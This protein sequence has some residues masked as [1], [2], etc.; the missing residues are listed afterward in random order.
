MSDIDNLIQKFEA[1][2]IDLRKEKEDFDILAWDYGLGIKI[3]NEG[4]KVV[5]V[6]KADPF[7]KL[8]P[9]LVI[10]NGMNQRAVLQKRKNC[11]SRLIDS[12]QSSILLLREQKTI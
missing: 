3:S 5:S 9:N 10:F 1:R 7:E 2:V 6:E 12:I 8:P 4:P 11:I